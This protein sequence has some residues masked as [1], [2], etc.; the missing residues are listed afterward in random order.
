MSLSFLEAEERAHLRA[1]PKTR[2]SH[3]TESECD[4]MMAVFLWPIGITASVVLAWFVAR[5]L[6]GGRPYP[7]A[8]RGLI[9]NRIVDRFSGVETVMDRASVTS[10]LHVLDAGCGPGRLTVP[11]ARRVAPRG[12]V[13]ALDVQTGMLERV[14]ERVARLRL[15]NVQTVCLSLEELSSRPDLRQQGF[16]R[17]LLVTVLGEV[18]D[19]EGAL[20]ALHAVLKP[21]GI[22]SV[23]E[24]VIDPDYVPRQT[25]ERLARR[26]GFDVERV[27]GNALA[28]TINFRKRAE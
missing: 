4:G 20:A 27:F 24:T 17:A 21:G 26:A 3:R 15:T 11:L 7:V 9:D 12:A 6:G 1:F 8:L 16:D 18:P 2:R 19:P 13:V 23:T 14:H 10:G 22:L 25:V 5:R 28:F